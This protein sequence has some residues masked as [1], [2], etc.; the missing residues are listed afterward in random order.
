MNPVRPDADHDSPAVAEFAG[1]RRGRQRHVKGC[2]LPIIQHRDSAVLHRGGEQV[3]RRL[4]DKRRHEQ[5]GRPLLQ[6]LRRGELLQ[7]ALLHHRDAVGQRNRFGLVM[8]H[9]HRRHLLR[10][11]VVLDAGAQQGA[12]LR[13]ELRHRL[14]QQVDR[15]VADQRASEAHPL[16]RAA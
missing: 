3:H 13:L 11:K 16:L 2:F 9:D 1:R 7:H 8:S 12:Q 15:G 6:V 4:A 10:D 14:V 5:I